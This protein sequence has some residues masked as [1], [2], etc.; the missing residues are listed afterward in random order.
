MQE[1]IGPSRKN[2]LAKGKLVLCIEEDNRGGIYRGSGDVKKIA[3]RRK[4]QKQ[5]ARRPQGGHQG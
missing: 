2:C 4:T 3:M 5:E 1:S